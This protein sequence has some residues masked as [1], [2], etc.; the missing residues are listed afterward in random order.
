MSFKHKIRNA[1]ASGV[2]LIELMLAMAILGTLSVVISMIFNVGVETWRA[3][4]TL[5]DE[6]RNADAIMEQVS[7]ALRSAYYPET[8]S[9]T[10]EYGF[11][12]I[13]G[14]ESPK[15][16]DSISWIKIGNSLIG[17]DVPW[18]GAA[19]R[20]ELRMGD[21]EAGPGL[22]VKAWQLAGLD[23]EFDP[24]EDAT[25]LLLSDQVVSF[26]VQM[27]DP[28][29]AENVGEPYEWLDEWTP[30]NR[31]P[32][33]ILVTIAVKPPTEKGDPL[34]YT[35]MLDIPM[36][37]LSWNPLQTTRNRNDRN[38]SG[39]GGNNS[40]VNIGGGMP[41]RG[42]N[43]GGGG[44]IGGGGNSGGAGNRFQR[45]QNQQQN[46][47]QNRPNT[48]NQRPSSPRAPVIGQ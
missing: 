2:T 28:D 33:H 5:A 9:P 38:T 13:D 29:Y 36:S 44:N 37:S 31:I 4:T 7:M 34:I 16:E 26:D 6:A 22:Y 21:E 48:D 46:R 45:P 23:D 35:R 27:R 42:G 20:V 39:G 8:R 10:Y 25:P 41:P 15:A 43:T 24:E 17:E 40:G 32:T 47:Q 3:G 1:A 18:A 14:G 19:H 30:S 12:H 11:Q